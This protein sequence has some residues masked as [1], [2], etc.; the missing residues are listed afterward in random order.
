[1]QILFDI[2]ILSFMFMGVFI[3]KKSRSKETVNL[4]EL[5]YD[6]NRRQEIVETFKEKGKRGWDSRGGKLWK[7]N[8]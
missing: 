1:M 5:I 8:I 4:G 6:F 2:H 3:E 7:V